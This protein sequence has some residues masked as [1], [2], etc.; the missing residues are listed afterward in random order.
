MCEDCNFKSQTI[1]TMEVHVGKC[2]TENFECGL[3]NFKAE[4]LENLELHLV[5]CEVYECEILK[6]RKSHI[7]IEHGGTKKLYHLKMN[8]NDPL[9]VDLKEYSSD[10]V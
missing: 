7:E 5:S 3:C 6:D 4:T 8:R 1:E 10:Q 2:G 9:M